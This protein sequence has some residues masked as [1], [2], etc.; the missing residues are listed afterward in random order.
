[1]LLF[2]YLIIYFC[3][4]CL[5]STLFLHCLLIAR[6]PNSHNYLLIIMVITCS[7]TWELPSEFMIIYMVVVESQ[8]AVGVPFD[9]ARV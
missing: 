4:C 1:M 3:N 8:L 2:I 9:F 7:E 5:A 6:F